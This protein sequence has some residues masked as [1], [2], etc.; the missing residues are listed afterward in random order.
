MPSQ[1][2]YILLEIWCCCVFTKSQT[3]S[4]FG[5]IVNSCSHWWQNFWW[6]INLYD[7]VALNILN[8]LDEK[9]YQLVAA[10]SS[11]G[12]DQPLTMPHKSSKARE[13]NPKSEK[14]EL[15]WWLTFGHSRG[16]QGSGLQWSAVS[17]VV[18]TSHSLR[19]NLINIEWKN[20]PGWGF[21]FRVLFLFLVMTVTSWEVMPCLRKCHMMIYRDS[22]AIL[23]HDNVSIVRQ[24]LED[25]LT[26]NWE[27]FDKELTMV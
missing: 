20:L 6:K 12:N 9:L 17:A 5:K 11:L 15:I 18:E 25:E 4:H 19:G 3:G 7:C 8:D 10:L 21:G 14:M 1:S 22:I 16:R 13:S 2:N 24:F 23:Y 27:W 26:M